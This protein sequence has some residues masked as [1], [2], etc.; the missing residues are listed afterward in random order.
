MPPILPA[1][2]ATFALASRVNKAGVTVW[3]AT[4]SVKGCPSHVEAA[5]RPEVLED[6]H[7]HRAAH[8]R[9]ARR[10]VSV[11]AATIWKAA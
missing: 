1:R 9:G 5:D 2:A 11:T 10:L 4:C 3:R 8:V 6:A 7:E